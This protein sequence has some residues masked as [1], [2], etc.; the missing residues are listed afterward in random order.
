MAQK[1]SKVDTRSNS[2]PSNIRYPCSVCGRACTRN[3][4]ECDLCKMWVHF[5]CSGLLA[6]QLATL[7]GSDGDFFCSNCVCISVGGAGTTFDINSSLLRLVVNL[8]YLCYN[9]FLVVSSLHHI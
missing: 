7:S 3:A 6:T 5:K 1:I 2:K 4:I 9:T 8:T